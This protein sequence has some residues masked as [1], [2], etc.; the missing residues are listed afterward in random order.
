MTLT[1]DAPRIV[2]TRPLVTLRD[3]TKTYG[4]VQAVTRVSAEVFP[5]EVLGI[6]GESGS[7][8]STLLRMM[9]LEDTP[10]SGSY[11]LDLPDVQG[12]LFE[13]GRFAR[14]MLCA[15]K[16]G[17]VYQ[18]PHLGLLMKHS[19][20]GNVA[21]RLL[22]AGE[23]RFSVLRDKA[24]AALA[25]SEFPLERLDAPPIELSGGMQQRVQLAKAIALE[26]ALLLLDEPTTGLDVSVQ[27]LVLDTLKR[28][29]QDRNITMVIVSHDLGVIRTL[30][31][32]VMV[33]R[34]GE[35]VEAGLVD[36]IFQ[37]PQ[38]PYTQQLVHAKL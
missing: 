5:G 17:I 32:R 3:V 33:M 24:R 14:R 23:R 10:D 36:Q 27:A 30:A 22:I 4:D 34:R 12:N 25:A 6:V 31:D 1:L 37:D 16:I 26:P 29:Q 9:N 8:K 38:H 7:G 20:S 19:S 2:T 21:E 28:L 15:T 11:T 35:V 13:L 18:N